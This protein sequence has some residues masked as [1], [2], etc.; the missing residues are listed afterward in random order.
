MPGEFN[1][2]DLNEFFAVTGTG[3]GAQFQHKS[4]VQKWLNIIR[5]QYMPKVVEGL[6]MVRWCP[7]GPCMVVFHRELRQSDLNFLGAAQHLPRQVRDGWWR[8]SG[9]PHGIRLRLLLLAVFRYDQL[10]TPPPS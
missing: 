6:K 1:E 8:V 3:K 2:F 9:R 4:D 5:G 10:D 7:I